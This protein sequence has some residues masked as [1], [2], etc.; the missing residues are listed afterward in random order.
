MKH[1]YGFGIEFH[2]VGVS[3]RTPQQKKHRN[4]Q[5]KCEA[6]FVLLPNTM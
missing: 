5:D 4:Q 3:K 6:Q 1:K 2:L